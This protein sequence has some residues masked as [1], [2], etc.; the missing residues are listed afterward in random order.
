VKG[1]QGG[2]SIVQRPRVDKILNQFCGTSGTAAI[3]LYVFR[4]Y[5]ELYVIGTG[6][7]ANELDYPKRFMHRI[8]NNL[9][10]IVL[11]KWSNV[12]VYD[13]FKKRIASYHAKGLKVYLHETMF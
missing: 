12:A 2:S 8:W 7:E 11:I 9:G 4:H 6:I 13:D 1:Y 3:Y 5:R 10:K